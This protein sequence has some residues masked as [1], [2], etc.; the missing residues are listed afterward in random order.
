[1]TRSKDRPPATLMAT[2]DRLEAAEGLSATRRRDALSAI[3]RLCRLAQ[4]SPGAVR[5]DAATLRRL[6]A[7]IRP[8]AHGLGPKGWSN[9]RSAAAAGLAAAGVIDPLPRGTART[10][11]RWGP[12]M[13]GL[14]GR[15]S[16]HGLA[17]FANWC[18]GQGIAPEAAD[19]AVVDRFQLWLELRTLHPQAK[20]AV[21]RVPWFW[22]EAQA[23]V[24]GWPARALVTS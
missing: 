5:A 3:R 7:G 15:R 6:I 11:P 23:Q 17:L 24:P 22:A 1:M 9:L 4:A 18:A 14:P 21:R 2:L 12:L 19:D 16:G 10:D 8:A 13:A 20:Q